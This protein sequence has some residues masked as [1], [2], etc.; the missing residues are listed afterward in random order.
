MESSIK[1]FCC[2]FFLIVFIIVLLDFC[3]GL[4]MNIVMAGISG[5]GATGKTYYALNDV[6]T[7]IVVVGSSRAAHHYVSSMI[8]DSM[9]LSTYNV[10][11]DGCFFSYN[12]CVINSILDRYTPRLIIWE[13]NF[14]SLSDA[15]V[16]PM[17]ALH[18]YYLKNKW[19]TKCINEDYGLMQKVQLFSCF[20]QY[21][22]LVHRILFRFAKRER[23]DKSGY[24]AL[25][26]RVPKNTLK[27]EENLKMDLSISE[28]KFNRI[29][30]VFMRAKNEN[31][32][33]VMVESPVYEIIRFSSKSKVELLRL[34]DKYNVHVIDNSQLYCFLSDPNLFNDK[35]HL[36]DN[37]A[38]LYTELFI[39]QLR[40]SLSLK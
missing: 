8:I 24:E 23:G 34:C 13:N 39:N 7:D 37:G 31:V 26:P 11:R 15:V 38:K 16:D 30:E 21:N 5:Q 4:V 36:N 40:D 1:H 3:F 10:G 20:Y 9:N 14:N 17:D 25:E 28:F 27:L 35:T 29:E 6:D 19:V 33:I 32:K 18:P 2:R 22:S 12:C